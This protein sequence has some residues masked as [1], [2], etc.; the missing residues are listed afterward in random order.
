MEFSLQRKLE[1]YLW[2]GYRKRGRGSSSYVMSLNRYLDQ[3]Y[4]G[5][6]ESHRKLMLEDKNITPQTI[7]SEYFGEEE[8]G[9]TL[10]ELIAYHNKIMY[11]SLSPGTRK[12]Y[13]I[14]ER[15]IDQFL[16]EEYH[17]EDIKLKRLNYKLIL[18][19]EQYLRSYRPSTK[20]V[21][22]NNGAMK[23]LE[24]L[25]KMSRLAVN[26]EW[27][28]KD[29]F[30]NF[31]LKFEKTKM[32]YLSEQELK[33]IE[34][35]TFR[36]E[37]VEGTKD[38]FLFACY[39]GLSYI[40]VKSLATDDLIRGIDGNDWLYLERTKTSVSLRIPLLPK[41]RE[42]IHKYKGSPKLKD[43]SSL[44]PVY[45]NQRMNKNLK[46]ICGACGIRKKVTFHTAR[47]TFAT[48]VTLSNGVPLE[49]V[50]KLLGHT[51]LRTTQIYA[52]VIE[53]KVGED[54]QRLM[55]KLEKEK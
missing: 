1:V 37:G 26:M 54:M 4:A 44:L 38:V 55:D 3:V 33:L 27:L 12:T 16:R 36:G 49:T 5:L 50:S 46:T 13:F 18:D 7:K 42:I 10:K 47:H 53:S 21:C 43:E 32:E 34:G 30:E 15:C 52:R 39:T 2:D 11:T 6:Y 17:M 24:R 19:F 35:T 28:T 40:D 8:R 31:K 29:P 23:H 48:T 41:A 51:K 20:T 22:N 45:S 9:S 25:K 14:T